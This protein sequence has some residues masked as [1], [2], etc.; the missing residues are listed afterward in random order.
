MNNELPIVGDAIVLLVVFALALLARLVFKRRVAL[1]H[2]CGLLL[3]GLLCASATSWLSISPV[4]AGIIAMV[5]GLVYAFF[6]AETKWILTA[7]IILIVPVATYASVIHDWPL[8]QAAQG[9]SPITWEQLTR[10]EDDK[11][12]F[13][14][15]VACLSQYAIGRE[16]R[17]QDRTTRYTMSP[18]RST[19]GPKDA[20]VGV[21][22][23]S[24]CDTLRNLPKAALIRHAMGKRERSMI[25]EAVKKHGL[26]AGPT[27]IAFHAAP[28]FKGMGTA[29]TLGRIV[30][31][32]MMLLMVHG[33]IFP[34]KPETTDE[35]TE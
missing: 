3:L 30:A 7:W 33:Q 32:L 5:A 21:W 19:R 23:A 15:G 20:P 24:S 11:I 22:L 27:P 8:V 16:H 31:I 35:E 34:G 17:I 14:E 13:V 9:S 29:L 28:S 1:V 26:K 10:V 6:V 12:Y 25:T 2:G 4:V 18:M